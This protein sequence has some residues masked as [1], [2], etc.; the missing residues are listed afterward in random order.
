MS[1]IK[2]VALAI[3]DFIVG[4]DWLTALGVVIALGVT[5]LLASAG[6]ATW[7]LLPLAVL[8]LL[9]LSLRRAAP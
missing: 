8:S 3:W 1:R 6:V 7:W 4:D 2:R 5:A 9:A